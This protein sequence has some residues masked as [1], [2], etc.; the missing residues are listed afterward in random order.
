[1]PDTKIVWDK[2][3]KLTWNDFKGKP[4]MTDLA[5]ATYCGID[6]EVQKRNFFTGK[7]LIKIAAYFDTDSSFYFDN[8]VDSTVLLHEQLHFDIAEW[9]ARQIRKA[10]SAE[11]FI[12]VRKLR[13]I[14]DSILIDYTK[15]QVMYDFETRH[16]INLNQQ[17][18][19]K[20]TI[21]TRIKELD[22]FEQNSCRISLW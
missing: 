16:G 22:A 6:V 13:S 19:W 10:V 1:M 4:A 20:E 15:N 2:E 17:L 8:K 12:T 9:H 5:A 3:R 7:T 21:S 11:R 14:Y 18:R